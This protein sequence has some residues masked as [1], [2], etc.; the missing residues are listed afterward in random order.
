MD[1][2]PL[3]L[4]P[5]PQRGVSFLLGALGALAFAPLFLFPTLLLSLSG[6]WFLLEKSIEARASFYK[7]FWLGWWFGLGHFTVGL[8]WISFALAV[9]IETFWWLIPFALF[10]IPSLL[11]VFTGISFSLLR[12]VGLNKANG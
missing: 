8:Y 9:D 12:Y 10:G 4:K 3:L 11:A 2:L 5:W 1:F 7:I 6:I